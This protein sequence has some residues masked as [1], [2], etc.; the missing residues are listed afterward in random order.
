[1]DIR[2]RGACRRLGVSSCDATS[3]DRRAVQ[4]NLRVADR[5]VGF[6]TTLVTPIRPNNLS[7]LIAIMPNATNIWM[8]W[9][10]P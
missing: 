9:Y 3:L 10:G 5:L 8:V 7:G 2:G 6:A 1:M 4:V